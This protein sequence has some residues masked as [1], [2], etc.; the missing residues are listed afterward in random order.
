MMCNDWC[1]QYYSTHFDA[2]SLRIG[3]EKKTFDDHLLIIGDAA[4]TYAVSVICFQFCTLT[5]FC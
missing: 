3:G 5:R 4:G 2:A 1:R